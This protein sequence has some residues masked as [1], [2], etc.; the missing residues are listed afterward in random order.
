MTRRKLLEFDKYRTLFAIEGAPA[1]VL[2]GF[3]ARLPMS[4]RVL[5]SILMIRALTGSY[6]LAGAVAGTL[7]VAQALAAPRLGRLADRRGQRRV[8]LGAL[9][10]HGAGIGGLVLAAELG[11]P[12]WSFFPPA[13]VAG[14]AALPLGALVRVRWASLAGGTP[15]LE[16]A[17]AFEGILDEIIYVVG[18][19]VVAALAV[20]VEPAAGLLGALALTAAG[21]LTLAA[22]RAT[23]PVLV[24]DPD[25]LGTGAFASAVVRVVVGA[26]AALGVLLGAVDIAMVRFADEHH[27]TGTAGPLLGLCALGSL[28]GGAVYGAAAWRAGQ[29]RRF[30][31]A[32]LVLS[33]GT[34]A[35]LL[36]GGI[37]AMA[38]CALVAGIGIAPTLIA[39]NTLVQS[40]LPPSRL[41]EGL[42]WLSTGVA[43]GV[44]VG[45]TA[46]GRL[47]DAAD[48]R[49]GFILA[50]GAGGFAV[51]VAALGRRH[52]WSPRG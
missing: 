9:A 32:T 22:Q 2:A 38:I 48:S 30:V 39:G 34:A 7:T 46:S 27:N 41:T 37:S 50:L 29:G 5:G 3:A 1:F 42:T 25:G 16:T 21:S 15:A 35:L 23:E 26:F 18:P 47:V 14:A 51:L 4:M 40:S 17:Y 45:T 11:A 52:L 31:G 8:L 43:V 33:V 49:A 20:G 13:V 12:S 28:V 10:A 19:V 36:P 6:V 44:A 24:L